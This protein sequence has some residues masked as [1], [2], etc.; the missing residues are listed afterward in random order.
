M[1]SVAIIP[2]RGG[3]KRVPRKNIRH[4]H[5]K[6][7]I[8]WAIEMTQ[9]S[10]LFDEII[11]STDDSEIAEIATIYGANVPFIRPASLSNDFASTIDVIEH[12][13]SRLQRDGLSFD[14]ACC[15]YAT[16]PLLQANDVL[17]GLAALSESG[18][19]YAYAVTDYDYAPHRALE[20]KVDGELCLANPELATTRSQ[21]LPTLRH[22][23]GQFYW[24]RTATWLSRKE[25]LAS[26]GVGVLI[27]RSRCQDIDTLDDWKI[28]EA[29]FFVQNEDL[30]L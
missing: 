22:D 15:V 28:A 27:P 18:A 21:D 3:S 6:P 23:A 2:A 12:A 7:M 20:E 1:K 25:I 10:D 26:R 13:V 19:D 16:A 11:V 9:R 24:A 4:F 14:F 29:L 5:G 8:A 17:K 30:G